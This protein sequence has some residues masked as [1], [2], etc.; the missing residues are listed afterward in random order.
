[1]THEFQ[2]PI[3]TIAVSTQVLRNPDIIHQ[4]ERLLN[5]TTIIEKENMRLKHQVERVLQM[6]KFDKEDIGLK[7]ENVDVH[8]IIS[9]AIKNTNPALRERNGV[10]HCDLQAENHIIQADRLHLTNVLYN[11]IDNAIKYCSSPPHIVIST[12]N[13]DKHLCIDVKDNG[14]G[15]AA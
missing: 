13:T 9:D 2:T 6:A 4:P 8:Q 14:L 15:I 12:M 11:L 5:Y 1:M 10:I 3:A 7:K